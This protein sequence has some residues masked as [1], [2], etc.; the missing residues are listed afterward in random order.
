MQLIPLYHRETQLE[1]DFYLQALK[2]PN[3]THPDTVKAIPA[4]REPVPQGCL[5][6]SDTLFFL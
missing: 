5:F 2:L 6:P 1:E 4:A 3:E